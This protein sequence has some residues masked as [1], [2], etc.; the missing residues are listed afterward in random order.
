MA[1]HAKCRNPNTQAQRSFYYVCVCQYVR[2]GHNIPTLTVPTL[3]ARQRQQRCFGDEQYCMTCD[4][5]L[6]IRTGFTQ[7]FSWWWRS[8]STQRTWGHN[9]RRQPRD[10]RQN[11]RLPAQSGFS[12]Q[13]SG[14]RVDWLR[15][16]HAN[17]HR[18]WPG[19]AVSVSHVVIRAAPCITNPVVIST[20]NNKYLYYHSITCTNAE[21]E[22]ALPP[23]IHM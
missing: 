14:K 10:G 21:K 2:H 1:H 9:R 7:T 23:P 17:R 18:S 13:S 11:S 15:R 3:P 20:N 6:C 19:S 16:L 12:C 22:D 8:V 5:I 4:R